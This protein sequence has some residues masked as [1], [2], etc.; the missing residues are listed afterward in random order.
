VDQVS[1]SLKAGLSGKAQ[2][3][4]TGAIS[5]AAR[6]QLQGRGFDV[7]ERARERMQILDY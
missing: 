1:Q 3:W 6:T 7:V 2:L 4:L 5:P